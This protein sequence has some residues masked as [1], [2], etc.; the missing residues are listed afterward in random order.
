MKFGK[1]L[2]IGS[3]LAA[4]S[5]VAATSAFATP[6][7]GT[8]TT[9]AVVQNKGTTQAAVAVN[10]YAQDGTLSLTTNATI[11]AGAVAEF[12]TADTTLPAGYE[13]SAVVS[14]DQPLAA[15]VSLKNS[16]VS[17]S[18][19][20]LT[21]GA[22]NGTSTPASSISFPSVWGFD[23]IGSVVT[24][25]NTSSDATVLTVDFFDRSGTDLGSRTINLNGFG[26]VT[27]DMGNSSDLPSGFPSDFSDGSISV[28]SS[29]TDIAGASTAYWPNRQGAYQALTS[30]NAGTVLYAPS[31][32]AFKANASDDEFTLFSAL[33]I[34]NTTATA[35]PITI[36]Y[37]TRGDTSGN[38]ALTLTCTVPANSA[39]G[40]NVKNGGSGCGFTTSSFSDLGTSWD[41]AVKV[42]S[43]NSINLV[44]TG[45]TNWG[46]NG[47]AG[48][49]AMVTTSDASDKIFIPAQY[50][51]SAG[52]WAQW[53]AINLQNIG[54]STV[55]AADITVTYIDTNG[56]TVATFTGSQL[57]SDLAAGAAF[58]LN[59]RN[60]GG[61]DATDFD[62]L[63]DSFIGGIIVE[64]PTGAQLVA[65]NNII[66]SNRASVY[67]GI[68]E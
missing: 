5:L 31:H 7:P 67:N 41:G 6:D 21:Q 19:G 61:L 62:G 33:N 42:T 60:G 64:G 39:V 68:P 10:Y 1:R 40:V 44:G 52:G 37:F 46:T 24:I 53:S 35:A 12:K 57:P 50:R 65:V 51:R 45:I 15:I 66:Y 25:Q 11:Q 59:T 49:Y 3:L 17:A 28:S 13:G 54:T 55:A 34:Q 48:M 29:A 32:F 8:A 56:N 4:L 23:G 58:G 16:G 22:Y 14:S 18:S 26:S 38:A 63:G 2:V 47:Y 20:S 30:A 27:I 36:E 9:N 43:D